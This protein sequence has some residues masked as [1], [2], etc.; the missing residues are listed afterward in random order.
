MEGLW[1]QTLSG[2][3]SFSFTGS[4]QDEGSGASLQ[5]SLGRFLLGHL[6]SSGK[7]GVG[8]EAAGQGRCLGAGLGNG[9]S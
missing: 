9:H 5:G 1:N 2:F 8:S 3:S 7:R 6:P 4:L